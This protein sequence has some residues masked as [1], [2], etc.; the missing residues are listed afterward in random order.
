MVRC[1]NALLLLLVAGITVFPE[2]SF[3]Q[4]HGRAPSVQ[5]L[6]GELGPNEYI[7]YKIPRLLAGDT[8]YVYAAGTSQNMDPMVGLFGRDSDF[9]SIRESFRSVVQGALSEKLQC[10]CFDSN[11]LAGSGSCV[12]PR[13]LPVSI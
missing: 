7:L 1:T 5:E 8:L 10:Y 11:D 2:N 13:E 4:G 12:Q 3:S 9:E 6:A